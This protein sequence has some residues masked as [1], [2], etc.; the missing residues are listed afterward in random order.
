MHTGHKLLISEIWNSRAKNF[1]DRN[2]STKT[3]HN[4]EK[5][6]QAHK[7]AKTK[8]VFRSFSELVKLSLNGIK[9]FEKVLN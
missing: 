4:N 5:F 9:L 8:T 1:W 2:I 7:H 3:F 6:R